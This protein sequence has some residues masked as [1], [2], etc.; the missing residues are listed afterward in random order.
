[1]DGRVVLPGLY[2]PCLLRSMPTHLSVL[3]VQVEPALQNA[4]EQIVDDYVAYH[5][6]LA[7]KM[8]KMVFELR[9]R[10]RPGH[11]DVPAILFS[12]V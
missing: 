6:S 3:C 4:V 8:G 2:I 9:P 10:V 11:Q 5:P 1:M 7:K 12:R